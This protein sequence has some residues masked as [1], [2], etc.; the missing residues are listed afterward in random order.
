MR[1]L[2]LALLALTASLVQADEPR[3][4]KGNTHT[5]SLWSDGNDFPEMISS[6]Y[7]ENGYDF[8]CMSDHNTLAEGDKWVAEATIE[9]KKLT[10]GRKVMEKCRDKF[11]DGWLVTRTNDKGQT[12]VKLKTLEEYRPKLEEAGKFLL[13]QAEE[14]S[15]GYAKAPIHIN[16]VNVTK[17]VQPL[18]DITSIRETLRANLQLIAA[19]AAKMGRPV[20]AHLN[21]PNFRW[22]VTAEDIAHV[23]EDQFFEVYNGHPSTYP[24]GDPAR[25][26]TST[27][28]IWDI[29]NTIRLVELKQPPL[30]ALGTDD[31]HHYHG[32]TATSGRGWV[33]VKADKLD[34][35]ALV[36]AMKRGDF[37]A[38][39]GVTLEDVSFD[40]TTRKLTVKI[41]G[42][43]GVKYVTEFRGTPKNYDRAV[44][45][46]PTPEGDNYPVRLKHSEDVGKLLASS[47]S[48]E[49]SYQM[50]GDELYVR[51][52]I[53]S[54]KV[55]KNPATPGQLQKAWT[56]PV[57]WQP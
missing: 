31:S 52:I 30:F 24:E 26:D 42:E 51:A 5:H 32:G 57:G 23:I 49:S 37:Y 34:P 41:K 28:R 19:E 17:A 54:D 47:E 55:M 33:M 9:K 4:Y 36:E 29:A 44:K 43:P 53:T 8:L 20:M 27:D 40:K 18:K 22:A 39:C 56:Q 2:P 25:A 15:A 16:A 12:E 46:V 11:G 1:I 6:W 10:L 35:N 7:K 38:S 45:E 14:V 48:L 3:W 21:H 50:K 13:V